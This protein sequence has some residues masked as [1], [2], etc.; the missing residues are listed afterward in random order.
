MQ[1]NVWPFE[2]QTSVKK[3]PYLQQLTTPSTYAC[4]GWVLKT[5]L[6][7]GEIWFKYSLPRE[8]EL[9]KQSLH[10]GARVTAFA[11]YIWDEQLIG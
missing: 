2:V 4:S 1:M 7:N 11:V 3:G 8:S 9:E 10:G 6:T 5:P